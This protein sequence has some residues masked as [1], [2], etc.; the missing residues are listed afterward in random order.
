MGA[1]S[2]IY[3]LARRGKENK[4]DVRVERGCALQID[5]LHISRITSMFFITKIKL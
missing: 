1:P 2:K 5:V 4:V 3:Q